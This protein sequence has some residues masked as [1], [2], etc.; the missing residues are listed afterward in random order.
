[1]FN[2]EVDT[3]SGVSGSANV[4]LTWDMNGKLSM[5]ERFKYE[6]EENDGN[7]VDGNEARGGNAQSVATKSNA[8]IQAYIRLD[9]DQGQPP[10]F[11]KKNIF[12]WLF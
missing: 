3:D 6:I 5:S 8:F 10:E 9:Q 4:V 1:M 12:L 11:E 7:V 2:S